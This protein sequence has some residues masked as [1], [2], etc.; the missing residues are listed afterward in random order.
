MT[1]YW[2]DDEEVI[3]YE[4]EQAPTEALSSGCLLDRKS[5]V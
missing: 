5:V 2:V 3:E 1:M 4:F